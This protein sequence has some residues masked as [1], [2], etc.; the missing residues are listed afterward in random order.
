MDTSSTKRLEGRTRRDVRLPPETLASTI[1]IAKLVGAPWN[2]VM[3]FAGLLLVVQFLPYLASQ[4]LS[5]DVIEAE[6]LELLKEAR[7]VVPTKPAAARLP[8][9]GEAKNGQQQKQKIPNRKSIQKQA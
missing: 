9:T 2:T 5:L 3:S 8:I 6:F 4:G 1:A 7:S